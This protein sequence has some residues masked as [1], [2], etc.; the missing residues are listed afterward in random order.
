M[1]RFTLSKRLVLALSALPCIAA[2]L[3]CCLQV[4]ARQLENSKRK[5]G[6][7]AAFHSVKA[8]IRSKRKKKQVEGELFGAFLEV[9]SPML[10][11]RLATELSAAEHRW[12]GTR[13]ATTPLSC[14]NPYR[15]QREVLWLQAFDYSDSLV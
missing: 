15:M 11:A 9:S 6:L 7:G 3:L 4:A 10:E 2:L 14:N 1:P 13:P 8:S 12:A 5:K